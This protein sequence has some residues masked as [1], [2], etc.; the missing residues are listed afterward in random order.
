MGANS[1][2]SAIGLAAILIPEPTTTIGGFALVVGL[3][4]LQ[5]LA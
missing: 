1:T 2:L 5:W 4:I 3:V